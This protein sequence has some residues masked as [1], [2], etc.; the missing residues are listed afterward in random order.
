M[1]S[2][3]SLLFFFL[4]LGCVGLLANAR[5]VAAADCD[6]AYK[7]LKEIQD[8]EVE[9]LKRAQQNPDCG[10]FNVKLGDIY[11]QKKMWVDALKNYDKALTFFPDS[12]YVQNQQFEAQKNAPVQLKENSQVDLVAEVSKRGLGGT[13]KLPPFAVE[14]HFGKGSHE[15]TAADKSVLDKFGEIVKNNYASYTFEVQ[16]HTD[17]TGSPQSNLA[18]SEKRAASVKDY[19]NKKQG[20]DPGK[21]QVKGYGDTQPIASNQTEE[22]MGQNRRVQFQGFQN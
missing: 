17:S 11:F 10:K 16:G 5:S 6:A 12:K 1:R 8:N 7:D 3:R 9:L 19:L 18:L 13:K 14:V 15:I 22:G 21:L 2:I 4:A 20:L